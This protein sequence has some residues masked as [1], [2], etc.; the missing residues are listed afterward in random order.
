MADVIYQGMH[1]ALVEGLL[2]GT[3]DVRLMLVMSGFTG[4][5]EE[6]AINIADI[7]TLDEFD[8][9]GYVEITCQNL[10][11]TYDTASDE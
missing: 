10:T 11:F 6:D 4:E 1:Y 3:P 8:G 2:S 7:S 5:T 9:I